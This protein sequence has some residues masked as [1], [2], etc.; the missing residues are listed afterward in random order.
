MWPGDMT[1][2]PI[3]LSFLE[4]CG[5]LVPEINAKEILLPKK[6]RGEELSGPQTK[7]QKR[8]GVEVGGEGEEGGEP[9]AGG[10]GYAKIEIY[11]ARSSLIKEILQSFSKTPKATLAQKRKIIQDHIDTFRAGHVVKK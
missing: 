3:D 7:K 9:E 5:P 8:E 1:S 6:R 11:Q 4:K 10:S 2:K